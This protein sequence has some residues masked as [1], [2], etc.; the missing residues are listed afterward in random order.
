[1]LATAGTFAAVTGTVMGMGMLSVMVMEMVMVMG[2]LMIMAVGMLMGVAMGHT[3]VGMLMA[4][5]MAVLVVMAAAVNMVVMNMHSGSSLGNLRRLYIS[6]PVKI[7]EPKT[8]KSIR[9][10]SNIP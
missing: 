8:K 2:V 7:S 1:M 4:M 5:G 6:L 3:V 10:C 9:R